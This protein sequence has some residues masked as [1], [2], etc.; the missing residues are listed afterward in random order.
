MSADYVPLEG[1]E[2][3]SE[4]DMRAHARA[5][6]TPYESAAQYEIFLTSPFRKISSKAVLNPPAQPPAE[7]ITNLGISWRFQIQI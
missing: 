3:L 1:Y 5:F 7:P 4:A 2:T 6:T